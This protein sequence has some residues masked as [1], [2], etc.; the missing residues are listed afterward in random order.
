MTNY[1]L[2]LVQE[3]IRRASKLIFSGPDSPR[4]VFEGLDFLD[5]YS[6]NIN[7]R[8][9]ICDICMHA[10]TLS[11]IRPETCLLLASRLIHKTLSTPLPS[12][13]PSLHHFASS[14]K[15]ATMSETQ[16][17]KK[18]HGREFYKSIG[19]PKMILAPMVDQSEFV[20]MHPS[21]LLW[22]FD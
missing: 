7:H 15:A 17:A 8:P 19:S 18:L 11:P 4:F 20:R 9:V 22:P 16:K 12:R 3:C 5:F 21:R 10:L 6:K 13:T 14:S 1:K 2:W